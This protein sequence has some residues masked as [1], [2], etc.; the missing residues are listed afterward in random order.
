M[1]SYVEYYLFKDPMTQRTTNRNQFPAS[2][3]PTLTRHFTSATQN[4]FKSNSTDQLD[5]TLHNI[6]DLQLGTFN[7]IVSTFII[8][9]KPVAGGGGAV[10]AIAPSVFRKC[11]K[12]FYFAMVCHVLFC[13]VMLCFVMLCYVMLCYFMLCYVMLCYVMLCYVMLCYVMLCYVMLC[14][15]MLCYMLCYFMLFYV[16]LCYVMFCYDMLCCAMLCYVMLCSIM[17]CY[18]MLMSIYATSG[19]DNCMYMILF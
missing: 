2:L 16:M 10:G 15:V 8:Q 4:T 19:K 11:A 12:I 1:I 18:V 3:T 17:L 5:Q 6:E 14:Y 7:L 9:E 13:N